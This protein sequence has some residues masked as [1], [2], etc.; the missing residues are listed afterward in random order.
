MAGR[1]T[2]LRNYGKRVI[3][4]E[5]Y[6]V[7]STRGRHVD[8]IGTVS[9]GTIFHYFSPVVR[10]KRAFSKSAAPR[11]FTTPKLPDISGSSPVAGE[12]IHKSPSLWPD[13]RTSV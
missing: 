3:D 10:I 1:T 2:R 9:E 6:R 12:R 4:V 7:S 13:Q 5:F 8:R 11:R